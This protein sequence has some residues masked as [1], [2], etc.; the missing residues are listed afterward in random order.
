M[1]RPITVNIAAGHSQR[2]EHPGTFKV[3][4]GIVTVTDTPEAGF[5]VNPDDVFE[6]F[7][8]GATLSAVGDSARVYQIEPRP[9][10]KKKAAPKKAAK[11]PATRKK[12]S[13]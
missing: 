8:G 5:V 6:V 1:S 10:P 13:K 9:E 12:V 2:I 3:H 11:K 4:S 7:K